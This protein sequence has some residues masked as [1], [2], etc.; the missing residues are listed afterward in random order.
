MQLR[1][2]SPGRPFAFAV[3]VPFWIGFGALYQRGLTFT[4]ASFL[5]SS[6]PRAPRYGSDR[7]ATAHDLTLC[8]DCRLDGS[9][10]GWNGLQRRLSVEAFFFFLFYCEYYTT[11]VTEV[12]MLILLSIPTMTL[13][14]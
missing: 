7:I 5:L 2:H 14:L 12:L 8:G 1:R 3:M 13:L 11:R 4:T 6:S 10:D 9:T